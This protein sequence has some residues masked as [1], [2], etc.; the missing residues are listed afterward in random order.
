MKNPFKSFKENRKVAK[1]FPD[2]EVIRLALENQGRIT[3]QLLSF[4][5]KL[6]VAQ[7]RWKLYGMNARG[8]FK[9]D[10]DYKDYTTLYVLKNQDMYQKF[11]GDA[12]A[13]PVSQNSSRSQSPGITDSEIITLAVKMKGK[14][15]AAALCLKNNVSLEEAKARLEEMQRKDVFDIQLNEKGA[16]IYVLNDYESF[17]EILDDADEN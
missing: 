14:L 17:R 13:P 10:Y 8:I 1:S 11:I 2:E 16:I 7:A 15:T 4:R 3:I 9:T 5:T 6:T 12:P